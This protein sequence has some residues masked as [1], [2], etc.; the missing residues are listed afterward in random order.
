MSSIWWQIFIVL[1]TALLT[2]FLGYYFADRSHRKAKFVMAK[3]SIRRYRSTLQQAYANRLNSGLSANYYE[4]MVGLTP[5][6]EDK[7]FFRDMAK[8]ETLLHPTQ[9][10]LIS[11]TWG[12][13]VEQLGVIQL[14]GS[15]RSFKKIKEK[16]NATFQYKAIQ[17][18][19]PPP[20][21]DSQEKADRYLALGK[22]SIQKII[23]ITIRK[24]M[25]ELID[26][27]ASIELRVF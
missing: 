23:D 3:A 18:D 17:I 14:M 4:L 8:E 13:L 26:G 11:E 5:G 22:E 21:T 20:N 10:L 25:D 24:E 7:I 6:K 15:E 27:L 2:S 19:G 1:F 12:R 9:S 16:A